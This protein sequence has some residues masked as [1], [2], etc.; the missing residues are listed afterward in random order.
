MIYNQFAEFIHLDQPLEDLKPKIKDI[1]AGGSTNFV[2]VFKKLSVFLH[3]TPLSE[4]KKT[5]VFFMTD[6]Q[7]TFNKPSEIMESTEKLQDAIKQ[8]TQDVIINVL[9]FSEDHDRKFL[10]KLTSIGTMDGSYNF[11]DVSD[12]VNLENR[13][14]DLLDST[15][16]TIG[17]LL[18]LKIKINSPNLFLSDWFGE[19]DDDIVIPAFLSLNE[20]DITIQT[21]KFVYLPNGVDDL[22]FTD[23]NLFEKLNDSNPLNYKVDDISTVKLVDIDKEHLFLR[24]LKTGLN[25]ITYKLS[26]TDNKENID[27]NI[28]IMFEKIKILNEKHTEIHK[29]NLRFFAIFIKS[30]KDA[31][32]EIKD[33]V[34]K[35]IKICDRVF[36]DLKYKNKKLSRM[37]TTGSHS[38]FTSCSS[39]VYNQRAK[40][41][42]TDETSTSSRNQ[43]FAD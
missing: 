11:I 13:M 40:K 21:N 25:M 23:I 30:N 17:K 38:S 31:I 16:Y 39:T 32:Q 34:N 29:I 2:D 33:C 3:E 24:K 19:R 12:D 36:N 4:R 22:L 42:F 18:Y 7:D 8:Y 41:I 20:E 43:K 15:I 1:R 6:G 14:I 9:G 10:E 37:T 27:K 35:G 26:K 28:K 5:F